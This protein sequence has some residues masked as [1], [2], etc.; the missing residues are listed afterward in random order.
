MIHLVATMH[1]YA[2]IALGFVP[3]AVL[4]FI[5][6]QGIYVRMNHSRTRP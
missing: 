6:R 2:L 4:G 3:G 5:V 1:P